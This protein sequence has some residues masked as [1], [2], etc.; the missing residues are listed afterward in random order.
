[1]PIFEFDVTEPDPV[2]NQEILPPAA[3]GSI[4]RIKRIILTNSA[5]TSRDL[6]V[7]PGTDATTLTSW[8]LH[9]RSSG[10]AN[11]QPTMFDFDNADLEILE[12]I[13]ARCNIIGGRTTGTIEALEVRV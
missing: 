11:I 12:G 8:L 7:R 10:S 5:S 6:S 13:Y 1:M 2:V 9:L 3:A 4:W